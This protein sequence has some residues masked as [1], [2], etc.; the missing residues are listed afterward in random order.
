VTNQ[1]TED[2]EDKMQLPIQY[3]SVDRLII[4]QEIRKIFK[5]KKY[6]EIGCDTDSVFN[7]LNC[8]FKIGVDPVRGGNFRM[9]SDEFFKLSNETFDL[10]FI[11]GLHYY[12]QVA[13]DFKN[14]LAR[15]EP[16]GVI[17]IHDI[18]PR[19]QSE[20]VTPVPE[21]LDGPWT[22]D[23]W[24]LA[25]DLMADPGINFHILNSPFGIGLVTRGTQ[26]PRIFNVDNSWQW[27]SQNWKNLPIVSC[28]QSMAGE[29][30]NLITKI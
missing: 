15:L 14:S 11:D 3:E 18:L 5:F 1:F 25:F 30:S 6:L 8:D 24:R 10:I 4:I 12:S 2:L 16:G 9:T 29:F 23:V 28:Y 19:H 7:H 22:G 27:Y 13:A 20:T 26:E 21:P 17:L